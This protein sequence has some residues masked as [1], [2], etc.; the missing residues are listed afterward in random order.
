M[1]PILKPN[2]PAG[3][4]DKSI[5]NKKSLITGLAAGILSVFYL[6][7][8]F[9]GFAAFIAGFERITFE[10]GMINWYAVFHSEEPF[11]GLIYVIVYIAPLL[12]NLLVIEVSNIILK[13]GGPGLIRNS[14]LLFQLINIGYILLN[15]FYGALSLLLRTNPMNDWVRLAAALRLEG[16]GK[17]VMML[18]AIIIL[19]SYLNI[20][21][22]RVGSYIGK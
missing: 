12:F 8:L 13:K 14:I 6:N 10:F 3:L 4:K 20:T 19:I 7:E 9:Q 16:P 2:A 18:F 17:F 21:T 15:I 5:R 11:G 1:L 22:K